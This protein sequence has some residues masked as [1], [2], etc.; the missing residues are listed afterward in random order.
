[1][2]KPNKRQETRNKNRFQDNKNAKQRVFMKKMRFKI[3]TITKMHYNRT[4][5]Y[6]K[7]IGHL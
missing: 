5:L 1:M 3:K 7:K 4:L 6:D 2:S